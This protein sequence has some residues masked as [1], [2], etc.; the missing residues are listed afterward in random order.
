MPIDEKRRFLPVSIAILTVS[1][2][3]TEADDRSGDTLV[4]RD[5]VRTNIR[6]AY[7]MREAADAQWF[8]TGQPLR[9]NAGREHIEFVV[10]GTPTMRDDL[11]LLG[12]IDPFARG[13]P[14][15][16]QRAGSLVHHQ[17]ASM[18][19]RVDQRLSRLVN[20]RVPVVADYCVEDLQPDVVEHPKLGVRVFGKRRCRARHRH[21]G[22][23][24]LEKVLH[25]F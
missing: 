2:T 16:K 22:T 10:T 12:E 1:D 14:S 8:V 23:E 18:V 20:E 4:E 19:T 6:E 21:L 5:G 9:L 15:A 13:I 25:G 3:R 11:V 7:T 24:C 17:R